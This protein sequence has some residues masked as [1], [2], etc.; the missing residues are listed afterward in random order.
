[1]KHAVILAAGTGD[2]DCLVAAARNW[3]VAC[4]V[5]RKLEWSRVG[6]P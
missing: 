2:A 4:P 5:V 6:K 3:E 1:M